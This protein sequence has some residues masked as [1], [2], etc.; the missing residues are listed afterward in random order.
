MDHFGFKVRN[1][2]TFLAKWRAEGLP[3]GREFIG[4]EGQRNAYIMMPDDVYVELQ[5][6]QMLDLEVEPYH[7]HFF[8]AEYEAYC[9][10]I[11][12][13]S[14]SRFDHEALS[15]APRMCPA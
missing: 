6:D 7:I 8:T 11:R 10:G 5:E 14:T 3:V 13:Y 2:A 9:S 4:A 12:S 1:I 15:R